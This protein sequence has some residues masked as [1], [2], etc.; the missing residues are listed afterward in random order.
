MIMIVISVVIAGRHPLCGR[1]K[2]AIL[3]EYLTIIHQLWRVP[4]PNSSTLT[5]SLNVLS[6]TTNFLFKYREKFD[7]Q[8]NW[9]IWGDGK[10]NINTNIFEIG[11]SFCFGT[12]H[13]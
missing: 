2:I 12:A 10:E 8:S 9:L 4:N 13:K 3:D 1:E 6:L 5:R 11:R 7:V